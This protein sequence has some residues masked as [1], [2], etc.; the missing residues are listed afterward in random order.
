MIAILE[1]RG[2]R[3]P[4]SMER[5]HKAGLERLIA[6]M[7]TEYLDQERI[8]SLFAA[9]ALDDPERCAAPPAAGAGPVRPI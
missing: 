6:A 2:V 4:E 9:L 7:A 3:V 5:R 1:R 8:S